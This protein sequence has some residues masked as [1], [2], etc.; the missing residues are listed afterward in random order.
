MATVKVAEGLFCDF[1]KFRRR[2]FYEPTESW[3]FA[4]R[5]PSSLRIGANVAELGEKI[6]AAVNR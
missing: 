4:G 3:G 5:Q 6:A 1:A 2:A